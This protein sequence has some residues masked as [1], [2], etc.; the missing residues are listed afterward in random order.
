MNILVTGCL[1]HIGSSLIGNLIKIKNMNIYGVDSNLSNNLNILFKLKSKKFNFFLDD[2]C[3]FNYKKNLKKIDIVIHLASITNAESSIRNKFKY[4]KNNLGIFKKV[5]KICKYF[6]AKLIH[7]SSTSVYGVSS[8]IVTEDLNK[9]YLKPQSPY[10]EIK[11]KEENILKKNKRIN[12]VS[13]RL[14]TIVGA[15]HGMRFHTAVNKFCLSTRYNKPIPVWKSAYNQYRPYLSIRDA[16]K[17]F[18]FFIKNKIFFNN[19]IYNVVTNN[20]TVKNIIIK[21]KKIFKKKIKIQFVNSRIMNQLS[22]KVSG[23]KLNLLGLKLSK[24][25]NIDIKN[26]KFFLN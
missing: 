19:E 8:D 24:D 12:F 14:G 3:N 5:I 6:D 7:V 11:L 18:L 16:N 22:Y 20:F 1:G 23:K 10:A 9:K 17:V 4:E 26:T 13:L 25:I 2:L 21:I 15:S